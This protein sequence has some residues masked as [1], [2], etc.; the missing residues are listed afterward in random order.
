M[1]S[2]IALRLE[3]AIPA[4]QMIGRAVVAKSGLGFALELRDDLLG[5][6]LTE[7]DAPLIERVDVPDGALGEDAVLVECNQLS[8]GRRSQT[9]HHNSVGRSVTFEHAVWD[10]PVGGAV[11]LDLHAGLPESECL[12]LRKYIRQQHIVMPAKP[13]ERLS[14][15]DEVTRNEP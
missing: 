9:I 15:G 3:L 14:E 10:E 1:P 8:Q 12:G 2:V 4:D 11:G 7:F 13:V 6:E 5:Q